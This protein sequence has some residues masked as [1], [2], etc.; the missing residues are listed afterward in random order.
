MADI[1]TYQK[2]KGCRQLQVGRRDVIH[3]AVAG[4]LQAWQMY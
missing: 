3:V 1:L 4:G 2:A